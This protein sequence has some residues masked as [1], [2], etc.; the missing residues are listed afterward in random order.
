MRKGPSACPASCPPGHLSTVTCP[1]FLQCVGQGGN[2]SADEEP[3]PRAGKGLARGY[4]GRLQGEDGARPPLQPAAAPQ[5]RG[6]VQKGGGAAARRKEEIPASPCPEGPQVCRTAKEKLAGLKLEAEEIAL[7]AASQRRKLEVVLGA[8]DQSLRAVAPL[9]R[10]SVDAIFSKDLLATLHLLVAL[11]RHF[12]PDL[13]LP[14][15]VRVEVVTIESTK[16]GLKSEKSVEL[17]TDSRTD[18]DQ[19]PKDIFD[20]LFKLAPE[21][22]GSMKEAIVSFVNQKLE[23]LGLSVQDLDTQFADGVIL[24]LLIGQLGGFFLH[25]KEFYLTP[26]SPAEMLHNVTLALDLLKDEGL[27]RQPVSP[28]DEIFSITS[29]CWETITHHPTER[30]ARKTEDRQTEKPLA[31]L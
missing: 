4:Q 18:K 2:P 12:Q 27:L 5:E 3:E 8:V 31:R 17:L 22:V 15:D 14:P 10:W 25:L 30:E 21:K 28:E 9:N 20:E 23:R 29:C 24:L 16:S 11:A 6:A 1:Y 13:A 26:S 7:N 19:A